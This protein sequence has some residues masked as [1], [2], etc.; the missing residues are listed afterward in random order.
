M[1]ALFVPLLGLYMLGLFTL[2]WRAEKRGERAR[3][4]PLIYTLS[5][6]ALCSSWTYFGAAGLAVRDGWAY[7]PNF[8][9]Q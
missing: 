7:L 4:S 3:G 6:A 2:A 1:A 9:G 8:L 5:L